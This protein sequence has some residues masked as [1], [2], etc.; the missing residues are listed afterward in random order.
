MRTEAKFYPVLPV[1]SVVKILV[2]FCETA[3]YFAA[4][5]AYCDKELK[6]AF[7]PAGGSISPV[8]NVRNGTMRP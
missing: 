6:N 4:A 7:A 3:S 5:C 1:S 2:A 8:S